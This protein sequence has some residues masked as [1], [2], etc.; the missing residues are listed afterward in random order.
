MW[1]LGMLFGLF[2]LVGCNHT[3][4]VLPIQ[5]VGTYEIQFNHPGDEL[6]IWT[7]LDVE[8]KELANFDYRLEF[9]QNGNLI[10]QITCDPLTVEEKRMQRF[11]DDNGLVKISHLAE[12]KCKVGLSQGETTAIVNFIAEGEQL[13][14][15]RADLILK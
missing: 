5:E 1:L 9:Y 2:Y 14:I 12:M 15:F 11:L 3:T 6:Q 10:T 4:V 13:T 8:F 7:D